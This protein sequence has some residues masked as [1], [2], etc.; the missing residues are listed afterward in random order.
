MAQLNL[1][2]L[3]YHHSLLQVNNQ[4][5]KLEKKVEQL[6]AAVGNHEEFAVSGPGRRVLP[7]GL[8]DV[9]MILPMH[10]SLRFELSM[11]MHQVAG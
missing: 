9:I 4:V 11:L 5:K 1:N 7:K 2:K 3:T 8:L 6:P 10:V